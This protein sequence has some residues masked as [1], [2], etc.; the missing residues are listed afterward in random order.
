MTTAPR[1]RS[2]VPQESMRRLTSGIVGESAQRLDGVA[3]HQ[4]R[5]EV[6]DR[7][8]VVLPVEP[9]HEVAHQLDSSLG[10]PDTEPL[11]QLIERLELLTSIHAIE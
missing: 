2:L 11:G 3:F 4:Y 5:D 1:A 6:P 8:T 9:E 10:K 7:H